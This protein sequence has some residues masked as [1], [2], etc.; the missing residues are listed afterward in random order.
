M[1]WL[2]EICVR[3]PVFALMLIMALVDMFLTDAVLAL[4]GVL[5]F[6]AVIALNTVYTRYAGP[7]FARAQELRAGVNA[8]ALAAPL[9][10]REVSFAEFTGIAQAMYVASDEALDELGFGTR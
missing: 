2:A 6:P 4:V 9:P 8:E 5:L 1:Y 10:T 3:R 7:R